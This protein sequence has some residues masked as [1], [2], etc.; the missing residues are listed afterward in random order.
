MPTGYIT[1]PN[2]NT[3]NCLLLIFIYVL[4]N[5]NKQVFEDKYN[6]YVNICMMDKEWISNFGISFTMLHKPSKTYLHLHTVAKTYD[7]KIHNY[8]Y[9]CGHF[10]SF[11]RGAPKNPINVATNTVLFK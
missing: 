5:N 11:G 7:V 2:N 9:C 3:L 8:L 10:L 4:L 6:S 1:R